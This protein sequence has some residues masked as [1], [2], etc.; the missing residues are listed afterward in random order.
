MVDEK[1]VVYVLHGED[2]FAIARFVTEIEDKMGDPSLAAL[3]L[4]RLDGRTF[5][6]DE[7]PAVAAAVP[8]LSDRRV[9]IL[10][11][12]TGKLNQPAA[13]E[14]FISVLERLPRTTALLLVEYETLDNEYLRRK[15]GKPH[16]LVAWAEAAGSRVFVRNFIL[17]R[18]PAMTRYIL[19]TARAAG[20]QFTPQAADM[21]AG[22]VGDDTRMASNEINKLLLYVNFS[23]PVEPDDVQ[24]LTADAS[25]PDIFAMVD[26]IG[27]RNGRQALAMLKGLLEVQ[28]PLSVFGM[29]VRQFRLLLVT[30]EVLDTGGLEVDVIRKAHVQPFVA[31]KL[32]PQARNFDLP[33]LEAIYHRLLDLDEATKTS[34]IPGDLALHTLIV[35]L[36]G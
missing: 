6:L 23:R 13:Q 20:G 16:W 9:V 2:E 1:P 35:S 21:L 12:F 5:N 4:T 36:S 26:A 33:T 27:S 29:V 25:E 11:Y 22:L 31:R 28:E 14:K 24:L 32:I 10:S 19:D 30:R 17:P 34:E 15:R 18:G 3:N 8:F 7:L